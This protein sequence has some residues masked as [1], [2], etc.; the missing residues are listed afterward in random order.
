[1]GT[2]VL[3]V[4]LCGTSRPQACL[5]SATLEI[6]CYSDAGFQGWVG[7]HKHGLLRAWSVDEMG[8]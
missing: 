8:F 5:F 3:C 6:F 2:A 7:H 4:T 1:M